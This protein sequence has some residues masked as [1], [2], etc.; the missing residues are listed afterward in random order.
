VLP[1]ILFPVGR[2]HKDEIRSMARELG[3]RVADKKDSQEI[4]FVGAGE[5]SEFVRQRHGAVD[6]AGEVVTVEGEVVGRHAGLENFTVG[7]RKGLK[8]AFGEPRYVIRLEPDSRRV[9]IGTREQLARSEFTAGDV[10]WLVDPP[11]GPLECQVKIRYL[12]KPVAATL[13]PLDDGRIS[14]V[15]CEPRDG[16]APGQAA[17]CYQGDRVLGGGWIQ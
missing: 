5:Y 11:R 10:N 16:V 15:L 13:T 1:R 17:V 7:Q 2:F 8:L 14:V 9:V 3:L 6:L 4:C 12:S